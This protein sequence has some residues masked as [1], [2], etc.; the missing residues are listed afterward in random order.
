MNKRK[1][2]CSVITS[3]LIEDIINAIDYVA[4]DG[5]KKKMLRN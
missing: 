5:E 2:L 1:D 4:D 3:K